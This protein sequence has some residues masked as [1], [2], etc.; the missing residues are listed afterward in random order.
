MDRGAWQ[1]VVRGVEESDV[2]EAAEHVCVCESGTA[3]EDVVGFP[4]AWVDL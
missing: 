2:A 3:V 1:T 4:M